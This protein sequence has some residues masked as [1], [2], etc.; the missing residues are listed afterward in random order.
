M[1]LPKSVR[2]GKGKK[3][4][5]AR[6]VESGKLKVGNS[7]KGKEDPALDVKQL[8]KGVGVRNSHH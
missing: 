6:P 4:N 8:V 1:Q 7:E 3:Q 5:K 2:G